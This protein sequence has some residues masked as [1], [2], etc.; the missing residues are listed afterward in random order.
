MTDISVQS[1]TYQVEDRSWLAGTHGTTPGDNPSCS[2]DFTTF[3]A[4]DYPNGYIPSGTIVGRITVSGK[5]GK[6]DTGASDGRQTAVGLLFNSV[7]VPTPTSTPVGNALFVH[8]F[9]KPSRLPGGS[10]SVTD[11]VKTALPLIYFAD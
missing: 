1:T 7:K 4:E 10:G 6:Y 5:V 9:V 11:A 8:G 3:S 2:V